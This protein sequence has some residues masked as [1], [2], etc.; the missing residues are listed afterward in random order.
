MKL[1]SKI[2]L[3]L[4]AWVS[5]LGLLPQLR[6]ATGC[7]CTLVWE[8]NPSPNIAGYAVYYGMSAASVTNRFDAGPALATTITG[9]TPHVN[10]FFY[11]V[12]YDTY[13][14]ES[15]PSNEML[16][17]TPPISSLQLG[18]GNGAMNIQLQVP[19]GKTCSVE[20]TPSLDPPT[21]T[22][23]KTAVGGPN[24]IVSVYDPVGQSQPSRFYR[25]VIAAQPAPQMPTTQGPA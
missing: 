25:A 16:Y 6:A 19:P 11:V 23:L 13:G 15:P 1:C 8:G 24:G 2:L 7:A 4:Y 9:L 10:Y 5:A 20:Y 12:D 17:A 18:S 22:L 21:W 3:L 14:D